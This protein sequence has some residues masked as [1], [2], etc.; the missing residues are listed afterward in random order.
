MNIIL[1]E[2]VAFRGF[3]YATYRMPSR[4][5][6]L[7]A[8]DPAVKTSGGLT[9]KKLMVSPASGEVVDRSKRRQGLKSTWA[10][11]TELCRKELKIEGMVLFNVGPMGKKL[12]MCVKDKQAARGP[13]AA[14][15]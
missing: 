4:A 1:V 10:K 8:K 3:F 2:R 5:V 11:D 6:T 14:K 13:V 15:K 7:H 9:A 12:Y